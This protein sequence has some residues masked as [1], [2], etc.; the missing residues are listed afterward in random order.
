M[1]KD[2]IQCVGSN[3]ELRIQ[4]MGMDLNGNV[5][6]PLNGEACPPLNGGL[7]DKFTSREKLYLFPFQPV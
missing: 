2:S 3:P 5:C 7:L 6:P 1:G 4:S